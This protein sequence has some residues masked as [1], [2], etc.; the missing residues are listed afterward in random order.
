MPFP[1]TYSRKSKIQHHCLVIRNSAGAF[2]QKEYTFLCAHGCLKSKPGLKVH[3][4]AALLSDK[5]FTRLITSKPK[6][7]RTFALWTRRTGENAATAAT[8]PGASA[9]LRLDP[10]GGCSLTSESMLLHPGRL[11]DRLPQK[12]ISCQPQEEVLRSLRHKLACTWMMR[13]TS[14][15]PVS[16]S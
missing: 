3:E 7:T 8:D 16:H 11:H 5:R 13:S 6:I 2:L 15:T 14:T 9:S 10:D 12:H 4:S 1:L